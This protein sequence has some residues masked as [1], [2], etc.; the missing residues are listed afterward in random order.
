[1][2]SRSESMWDL[3]ELC[4]TALPPPSTDSS[5]RRRNRDRQGADGS[6]RSPTRSPR[7]GRFVAA[8]CTSIPPELINSELFGHEKGAFTAAERAKKGLVMHAHRGTLFLDEIGDMPAEG[9]Q[10]LLRML[11]ERLLA[12]S[13]HVADFI[14]E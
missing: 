14:E 12:L 13:G 4:R 6:R 2:L 10:T 8:N 1:M 5:D 11:Q 3:F 7:Q 9:Q